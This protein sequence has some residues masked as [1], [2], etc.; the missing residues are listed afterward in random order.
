M[1]FLNYFG[2]LT[3]SH[4]SSFFNNFVVGT[5]PIF[6]MF[7]Q[8]TCKSFEYQLENP[9]DLCHQTVRMNQIKTIEKLFNILAEK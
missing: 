5:L 6:K 8:K 9:V 2:L 3:Y 7:Y 1:I 4:F